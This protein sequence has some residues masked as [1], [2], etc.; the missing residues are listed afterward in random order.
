MI[1]FKKKGGGTNRDKI[2]TENP[3]LDVLK[4]S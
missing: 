4:V 3:Q 2:D 1:F